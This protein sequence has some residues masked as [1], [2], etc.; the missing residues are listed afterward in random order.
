MYMLYTA[1]IFITL[2]HGIAVLNISNVN[3]IFIK[4]LSQKNKFQWC[5]ITVL[6]F[7]I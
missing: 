6:A 3:N 2:V 5:P 1:A 4:N 7:T